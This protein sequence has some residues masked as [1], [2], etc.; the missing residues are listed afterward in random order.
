MINPIGGMLANLAENL[1]EK[2][3][4][5]EALGDI[6]S[7]AVNLFSGNLLGLFGDGVDLLENVGGRGAKGKPASPAW[8]GT[9][10]S[11]PAPCDSAI[12]YD[13]EIAGSGRVARGR[14]V[15][16]AN[17]APHGPP[18]VSIHDISGMIRHG[19]F[20]TP[21]GGRVHF[22]RPGY[23]AGVI[24]EPV[25]ASGG[26]ASGLRD[27]LNNPSLSVEDKIAMLF[28]KLLEGSDTEVEGKMDELQRKQQ[29]KE[30]ADLGIKTGEKVSAAD[31]SRLS[32]ELQ[33]IM[34]RRSQ[35]QSLMSN[36]MNMTHQ[37]AMQVI[38][39]IR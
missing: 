22:Q 35:M 31:I 36:L 30:D 27:I 38:G 11:C 26:T 21:G 16:R 25:R 29:A 1:F 24:G 9:P 18:R 10:A 34:Q 5:S 15:D 37:S 8:H 17:C 33:I 7:G 13:V 6:A 12:A 39:N 20:Q 28:A 23:C 2:L 3:T 32:S 4:G 14:P 19:H